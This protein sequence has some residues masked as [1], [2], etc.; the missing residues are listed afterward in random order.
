M[1]KVINKFTSSLNGGGNNFSGILTDAKA[2]FIVFLLALPLS[3]GIAKASDFP[4]IMG[5]VTAIIGGV[6]VSFYS[7]SQLTIKGPAAGLIVIISGAVAE[8]GGGEQGW[9]LALGVMFVA[10]LVQI[11]FGMMKFGKLSDFFPKSAIHG[12]LAAI[13]LIIIIKQLPV[14]LNINPTFTAGDSP[15]RIISEMPDLIYNID[16]RGAAIGVVSLSVLLLWPYLRKFA[17]GKVP[18]PLVVLALAI[19]A[20]LIMDFKHTEPSYALVHIGNLVES[21]HL[22]V[23]FGGIYQPWVFLKYILMFSL[24]GSLESLLTVKAIDGMDPQKR[25]SDLNKDLVGVG[26]GNLFSSVLGGVPMISEVARSSANVNN[27]AQSVRANFFH[28]MFILIF[29]LFLSNY[30]E[31]I[32]NAALAAM[33]VAVGIKLAHPNEFTHMFKLG[34]DQ[35]LIFVV[36]IL[37]TLLEDLLIGIAAGI[38]VE[39]ILHLMNG[40]SVKSLFS[41]PAKISFQNGLYYLNVTEPAV[42]TNLPKVKRLLDQVPKSGKLVMNL[43]DA[44][45]VDHTVMVNLET[46]KEDFQKS[47]GELKITGLENHRPVSDHKLCTR[48]LSIQNNTI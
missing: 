33:L 13:G 2:G 16:F 31:M 7:G 34:K 8:F 42:F 25:V 18:A 27:G 48:K 45:L 17:L 19:P 28:G 6:F 29:V 4:P 43:G 44:L 24:V 36:T 5:L 26:L 21:L 30:I 38:V 37:V 3:I 14:L 23:D 47:G 32:P 20:E 22:N 39:M 15:F 1:N 46:L 41:N 35:L 10:A 9:H 12:M 40:A 11:V